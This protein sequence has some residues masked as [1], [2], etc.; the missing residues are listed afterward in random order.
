MSTKF[1]LSQNFGFFV[2][3]LYSSKLQIGVIM[4]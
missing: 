1:Y 3:A 2:L 4:I